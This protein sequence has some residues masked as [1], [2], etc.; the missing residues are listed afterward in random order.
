[1]V[2]AGS[3]FNLK[4]L[5]KKHYRKNLAAWKPKKSSYDQSYGQVQITY[6]FVEFLPFKEWGISSSLKL[7]QQNA[8][9]S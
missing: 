8:F 2:Q 1:M 5:P 9:L 6:G 4:Y 3:G 7:K